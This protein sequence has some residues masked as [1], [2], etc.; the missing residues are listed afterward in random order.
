MPPTNIGEE[1]LKLERTMI[2]SMSIDMPMVVLKQLKL[3]QGQVT[4][5]LKITQEAPK[6]RGTKIKGPFW[7]YSQLQAPG[8][9]L[10]WRPLLED[11]TKACWDESYFVG[12]PHVSSFTGSKL[13]WV[14]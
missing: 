3:M 4:K 12:L 6:T 13:F 10:I 1:F 5:V 2:K 8:Y 11:Q 9:A 14:M 7:P